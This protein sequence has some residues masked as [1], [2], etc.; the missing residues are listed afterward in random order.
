MSKIISLTGKR[1]GLW[2]VL[3]QAEK[4]NGLTAWQCRCDCGTVQDVRSQDLRSGKTK[5]CGCRHVPS[6]ILIDLTGRQFGLLTVLGRADNSK[7]GRLMWTCRCV[8]GTMKAIDGAALRGGLVRSCSCLRRIAPGH[9]R[10]GEAIKGRWS[11]EYQTWASI[12]ARCYNSRSRDYPDYGGRG[13]GVCDRW[14]SSFEAFLKDMGRRPTGRYSIDRIDNDGPY[15]PENCRWATDKQQANNQRPRRPRVKH[16]GA[17]T[18][19]S[20]EF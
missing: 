4:L 15:S 12:K 17:E 19:R 8:C 6:T 7:S 11:T 3:R 14:R 1:F 9:F 10:H 20:I 13:I 16:G 2:T 5:S 18:Q